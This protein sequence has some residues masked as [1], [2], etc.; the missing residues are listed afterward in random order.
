MVNQ[1]LRAA[2]SPLHSFLCAG[3]RR[4][5]SV[6][7]LAGAAL[8]SLG[9]VALGCSNSEAAAA[10]PA[11]TTVQDGVQVVGPGPAPVDAFHPER[12]K[13]EETAPKPLYGGRA[14]VHLS[15]MPENVNYAI[16]NSAVAKRILFEVHEFLL[17][18][19]WEMHDFRPRAAESFV[20]E[21][22]LVLDP[23][24]A[25][26]YGDAVVEVPVRLRSTGDGESSEQRTMPVVYGRI[27]ENGDNWRVRPSSKGSALEGEL[28]VAKEHV[29]EVNLGSVF[30]FKL[31]EGMRWHASLEFP[32]LK[33]QT[34]D[35]RD[36]V[37]SW[38][39][40]KNPDVD[41]D[42][43]RF[44]F[45]KMSHC[46][47]VDDLTVRFFY[48]SQYAFALDA[49]GTSLTLLP[50]HL[51]D[52][53]DPDNPQHDA[54]A[55]LKKQ[56][57][58]INE[59]PHNQLW[60]GLGPYRVTEYS[61]Q[62]IEAV[63][64]TGADGKAAYYD[65]DNAGYVDTIRWR[66]IDDD[67][68]ALAAVLNGE[69]DFFE[70]VKSADYFGEVT[71]KAEFTNT[72]Y[73]GYKYLG[74]YGYTA[75]NLYKPQLADLAVRKAMAHAFDFEDYLKTNYKGLANQITGPFPY[76]S[77]AYD[78][79][80][81]PFPYD[82]ELAMEMLDDAEWFDTNGDDVRDKDGVELVIEF[83][84][85]SGNDASKNF[86]LKLQESMAEIGIK[87]ELAQLEWATFIEKMRTRE[88]DAVNLAWVPEL[89]SDPEQ[90]WHSRWGAFEARSSNNAGVTDPVLDEMILRGQLELDKAKRQ[91]IWHEMHRYIY[92]NIQPY[93]FMYNVPQKFAMNKALRGFQAV[94]ID[95]GY[96]IRRWHYVDSGI[97]GTRATLDR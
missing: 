1:G 30:T 44:N 46:E 78:H 81:E 2:D 75:W 12:A 84:F 39:I 4:G 73:K 34:L 23:E 71:R 88:F 32:D 56:A 47:A 42:E 95:P 54:E 90:L 63:R 20:T 59:N 10:A 80:V 77:A 43:K 70:R 6:G 45:T 79:S 74:T 94:P 19:D 28:D 68:T 16:E 97:E 96:I 40:Y 49:I 53:T 66:Y 29:V 55:S 9:G 36:V 92:T 21:D 89:E 64:F 62:W 24:S 41:C 87:I 51:F 8:L 18:Q 5:L 61:Q 82:P 57:V 3:L 25:N 33:P 67:N 86:G 93:M 17:I 35:A 38:S 52:L 27:A 15:S 85:P 72:Y 60:V 69:L 65:R 37:F 58:H 11:T 13:E 26:A 50:S 22:M 76:S 83:L 14:I 31:R 48:E 91:E 7:A